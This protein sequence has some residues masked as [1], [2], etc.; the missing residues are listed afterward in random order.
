[1]K[2]FAQMSLAELIRPE[3]HD[4]ACGRHHQAGLKRLRIGEGAL[5][6]LPGFLKD[7]QVSRP[8]IIMDANTRKAAWHLVEPV[9][10]EAAIPFSTYVFEDAHLEPDE[11][12]LGTLVMAF[13]PACDGVL[14]LGSG[15]LNDL[16]K[17][18]AHA[19]RLPSLVVATAPSMDG[20]A[21]DNASMI[22]QR[23]KV[24]FYNACPQA[25]IADTRILKEA[26]E[27]MLQAGLGDMLAKYPSICEWR[28]SHLVTGEYYCENIAGLVRASLQKIV[29]N[30]GGLKRREPEA[31]EA[32]TEG[33][34]LSGIAMSFAAVSRPASGLEHYFSHLW[35]MMAL[36]R[37]LPVELHGIQVGIGTLLTLRIWED[38]KHI[39]PSRETAQAFIQGFDEAAWE[40]MVR[41]IF[42]SAA[43]AILRT[44]HMEGRNDR[45]AHTQRLENTLKNWAQILDIVEQELP[46]HAQVEALMR[47]MSMPM[48]PAEIGFDEKDTHDALLGARE[49]RN[50]Y[51]TSSLLWD[52]G[53][54]YTIAFP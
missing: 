52:L 24:S 49:I 35:E 18:F 38:L 51:L 31:V 15:V 6:A 5:D 4:C 37:G 47:G 20:Y 53:L 45:A 21:S 14:A 42:G 1:M 2:T 48:T 41:R 54:L 27:R 10:K 17:V 28:I 36:E 46:A 50:K 32:V 34:V 16:A 25:I 26:P 39:Q 3:G 22:R 11:Q 8:F 44:A 43:P 12:A 13:D 23:V 40:D 19:V 29:D 7:C 30:A 9:L 33:L